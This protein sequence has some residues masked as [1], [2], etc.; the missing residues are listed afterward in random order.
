VTVD[1]NSPEVVMGISSG[2]V[3]VVVTDEAMSGVVVHTFDLNV[4]PVNVKLTLA[5]GNW[6][7]TIPCESCLADASF[8][9]QA[10]CY[11]NWDDLP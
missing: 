9:Y 1:F 6:K 11:Y 3:M 2:G 4:K 8:H 10:P 5:S 7:I